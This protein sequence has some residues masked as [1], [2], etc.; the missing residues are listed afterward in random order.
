[1]AAGPSPF[2]ERRLMY[3]TTLNDLK[4]ALAYIAEKYQIDLQKLID[5]FP[6]EINQDVLDDF[7]DTIRGL[8]ERAHFSEAETRIISLHVTYY[9]W[10]QRHLNEV[11]HTLILQYGDQEEN[12]TELF[13]CFYEANLILELIEG[14]LNH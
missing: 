12:P 6:A 11:A 14:R 9:L 8:A 2:E 13:E 3:P 7:V 4:P 10:C 5:A 1:M